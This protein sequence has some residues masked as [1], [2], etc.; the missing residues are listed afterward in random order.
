MALGR[1]MWC[2]RALWPLEWFVWSFNSRGI[3]V[4]DPIPER[5]ANVEVIAKFVYLV[6][7]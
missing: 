3:S 1:A 7:C 5:Q 2:F 6:D 4:F